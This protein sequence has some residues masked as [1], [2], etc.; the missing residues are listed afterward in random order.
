LV[1]TIGWLRANPAHFTRTAKFRKPSYLAKIS[2]SEKGGKMKD[3]LGLTGEID[4]RLREG[5][6]W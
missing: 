2:D 3:E 6:R 1:D 4:R 5:G